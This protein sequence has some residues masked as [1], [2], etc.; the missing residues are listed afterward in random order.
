MIL[1]PMLHGKHI[2]AYSCRS[3]FSLFRTSRAP[4]SHRALKVHFSFCCKI[5]VKRCFSLVDGSLVL[6]V[7]SL[8]LFFIKGYFRAS[9]FAFFKFCHTSQAKR[10]VFNMRS[11]TL[12]GSF[13]KSAFHCR[14]I[15]KN[16]ALKLQMFDLKI[17][18]LQFR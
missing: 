5:T 3:L 14:H 1:L 8:G 17:S 7:S 9:F 12:L 15:A 13:C 16:E 10:T 18:E 11:G 2:F 4:W 6:C